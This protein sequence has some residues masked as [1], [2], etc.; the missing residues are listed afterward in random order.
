MDFEK[1]QLR[2]HLR[3]LLKHRKLIVLC[4]VA[5]AIPLTILLILSRPK[6]VSSI[7]LEV[8]DDAVTRLLTADINIS[9]DLTVGNYM[10]ILASQTFLTRVVNSMFSDSV[11]SLTNGRPINTDDS[12]VRDLQ[13]FLA[14]ATGFTAPP[15]SARDEAIVELMKRIQVDHRGGQMIKVSIESEDPYKAFR[16]ANAVGQ[17]F[18]LLNLETIRTRIEVLSSYYQQQIEKAYKRLRQA[19]DSLATFRQQYKMAGPNRDSRRL[20]DRLNTLEGQMIELASQ[21]K[22]LT[23]RLR[24]LEEQIN[25]FNIEMPTL[26]ALES[27]IPRIDELKRRLIGLQ[28]RLNQQT[29]IYTERHP[30]VQSIKREIDGAVAELRSLA[31]RANPDGVTSPADATVLW[32]DLYIEHLLT[33]V[34]LSNVR[35]REEGVSALA[36]SYRDRLLEQVSEQEQVLIKLERE[37]EAARDAYQAMLSTN[38]KVQN[39]DAEKVVNVNIVEPAQRPLVPLPRKRGLKFFVGLMLGVIVG[40]A[41]AYLKEAIDG[42]IK[43]IQD[44]EEKLKMPLLGIVFDFS[45]GYRRKMKYA[46][47]RETNTNS[48]TDSKGK[49]R[50]D[51][52]FLITDPYSGFA[53]NFRALRT[54]LDFI[55]QEAPK[56]QVIMVTSPGPGEG[57]STIAL[58]LA[59]S[60][61]IYGKKTLLLDTD[62]Y[63][64]TSHKLLGLQQDIGLTNWLAEDS[65]TESMQIVYSVP[66]N[67]MAMD[68]ISAGTGEITFQKLSVNSKIQSLFLELREYYDVIIV[69]AP[70][71]IPVS[72]PVLIAPFVDIALLVVAAGETQIDVAREAIK[73]LKRADSTYKGVVLNRMRPADLYGAGYYMASY[74][75]SHTTRAKALKPG[76]ER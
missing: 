12:I 22:V 50:T 24:E 73:K 63:R 64:P 16:T 41:F 37:V 43:S 33:E 6:Y 60:F 8:S 29:A 28:A 2:E 76:P 67:G 68:F 70:P 36:D 47:S 45:K 56:R 4:T 17:E 18:M 5:L 25:N 46:A 59:A 35:T 15:L 1:L 32:H 55:L 13:R 34:E 65:K 71:V 3:L 11:A 10:D 30:V 31:G 14:N 42:S 62:I 38:E 57:K 61:T 23:D 19:E 75:Q 40:V 69:D 72:D 27:Q 74:V 54:N 26:A 58:N 7:A 48:H 53:E 51:H 52:V 44:V 39:L 49:S 9:P 21:R 20:Y 66:L